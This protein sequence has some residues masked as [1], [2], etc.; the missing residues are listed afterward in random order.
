VKVL[1]TLALV[2]AVV[3]LTPRRAPAYIDLSSAV[4]AHMRGS[5]L[6][7]GVH[8][9]GRVTL[10]VVFRRFA[11]QL[12]SVTGRLRCRPL[13]PGACLGLRARITGGTMA[14][15]HVAGERYGG[16]DDVDLAIVFDD[17]ALTCVFTAVTIGEDIPALAGPIIC[18]DTTGA[19]VRGQL[20]LQRGSR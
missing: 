17:V 2:V 18:R 11:S 10:D 12:T 16:L 19:E 6:V 5:M 13:D 9:S 15:S 20:H 14:P 3:V 8:T 7:P 4:H 1:A